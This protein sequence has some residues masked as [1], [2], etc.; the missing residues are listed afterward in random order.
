MK[1][2]IMKTTDSEFDVLTCDANKVT[3]DE[4]CEVGVMADA[5]IATFVELL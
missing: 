1:M 3:K 2:K 4:E 5:E